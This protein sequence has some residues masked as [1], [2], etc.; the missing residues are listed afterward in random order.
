MVIVFT[1]EFENYDKEQVIEVCMQLGADCPKSL[2]KKCNLLIQ[3]AYVMDHFKRRLPT[4]INETAKSKE[5]RERNIA[6]LEHQDLDKFFID[7]T[8]F[9]LQFHLNRN[10]VRP[11][12]TISKL[13]QD[14]DDE[15]EPNQVK[16]Q[17]TISSVIKREEK[18]PPLKKEA[19]VTMISNEDNSLWTE[20]YRPKTL[21]DVVG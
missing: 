16:N 17:P 13:F 2:T 14:D 8:G 5:A 4:P 7:K 19:P 20:K 10:K 6:I 9:E 18:E 1:G 15:P 11:S 12:S 21:D 3:G